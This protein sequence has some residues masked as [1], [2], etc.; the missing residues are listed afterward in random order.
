MTAFVVYPVLDAVFV[1]SLV[2]CYLVICAYLD[3]VSR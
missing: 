2:L 1:G 3:R